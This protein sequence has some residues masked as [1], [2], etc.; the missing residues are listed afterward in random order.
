MVFIKMKNFYLRAVSA[1]IGLTLFSIIYIFWNS[2]GIQVFITFICLV[3]SWEY[4][5]LVI[6]KKQ[7]KDIMTGFCFILLCQVC[8]QRGEL[9]YFTIF[10]LLL[11]LSISLILNELFKPSQKSQIVSHTIFAVA[12]GVIY[13]GYI[14]SLIIEMLKLDVKWIFTLCAIVFVGDTMAYVFGCFL[15]KKKIL[16]HLS[17]QKTWVGCL[18]GVCG[19]GAA[20]FICYFLWYIDFNP[21]FFVSI[22]IISGLMGQAGDFFESLLKRNA[23]VKDSGFFMPG[24]GG[25]LDRIDSLLFAAPILFLFVLTSH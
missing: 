22:S 21:L 13:L 11:V 18:G 5:N 7:K 6:F 2:S 10:V 23:Q 19:S 8:L 24:H 1:I 4:I 15:G 16:P 12:F 14:P 20:G 17:P 9:P 3:A 25:A